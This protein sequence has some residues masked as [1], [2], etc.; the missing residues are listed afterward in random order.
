MD[1]HAAWMDK[2][3]R[4]GRTVVEQQ[5]EVLLV[6]FD[7]GGECLAELLDSAVDTRLVRISCCLFQ[8]GNLLALLLNDLLVL[9][10]VHVD[11]DDLQ[12]SKAHG[13]GQR[14]RRDKYLSRARLALTLADTMVLISFARFAYFSVLCVS[15]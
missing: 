4:E 7:Q 9:G 12:A 2:A 11:A 14:W 3:A 15:S 5:L 1:G 6:C 13:A 8:V 10:H